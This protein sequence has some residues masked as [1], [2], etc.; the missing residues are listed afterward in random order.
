LLN[1]TPG[2]VLG[3]LLKWK[4]LAAVLLGGIRSSIS[5]NC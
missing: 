2:L 3:L 1:F 4:A 5:H